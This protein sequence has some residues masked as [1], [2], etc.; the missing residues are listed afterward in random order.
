MAEPSEE[1]QPS[2]P[3]ADRTIEITDVLFLT[4][5]IILLIGLGMAVS[6]GVGLAVVGLILVAFSWWLISPATGGK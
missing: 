4:G 6:W 3:H 1:K 2:Q 5:L